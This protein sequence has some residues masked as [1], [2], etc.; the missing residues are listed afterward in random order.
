M[1]I[2]DSHSHKRS[3]YFKD[4]AH[5]SGIIGLVAGCFK[6]AEEGWAGQ[7]QHDWWKGVIIKRE[8]ENGRYE[9]Q[10]VSLGQLKKAY[11]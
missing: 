1:C 11:G 5:P 7:A 6:G 10:F 9:P 4:G 3:I 2:R 8:I